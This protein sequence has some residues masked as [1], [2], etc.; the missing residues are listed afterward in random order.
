[1]GFVPGQCVVIEDSEVGITAA[2]AA[3][4]TPLYYVQTGVTNSYRTAGH[5]VFDDMARLPQLLEHFAN[6]S[7][8]NR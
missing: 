5:V 6:T 1:M 4:M 3:G 8:F 2:I 7:Q